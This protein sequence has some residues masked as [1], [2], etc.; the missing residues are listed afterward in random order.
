MFLIDARMISFQL[1]VNSGT[2]PLAKTLFCRAWYIV[3]E[4]C[5]Y[6]VCL[7][8]VAGTDTAVMEKVPGKPGTV[9]SFI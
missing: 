5:S 3:M 8:Q 6:V 7:F 2:E 9:M 1:L 4:F